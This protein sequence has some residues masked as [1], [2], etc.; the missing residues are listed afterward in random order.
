MR[1]RFGPHTLDPS[2]CTLHRDGVP[3]A[4]QPRV[5]DLIAHLVKHRGRL[6]TKEELFRDVWAGVA[7][8][9]GSLTQTVMVARKVLGDE[10]PAIETSRGRGY[11][12][13]A[14]VIEEHE[15]A[16]VPAPAERAV[17]AGA[18]VGRELALGTVARVVD[19]ARAGAMRVLLVSGEPGIGKSRVLREA[20]RLARERGFRVLAARCRDGSE[21]APAF[22]PFAEV[23][24]ALFA[25]QDP[26]KVR[27]LLDAVGPTWEALLPLVPELAGYGSGQP[28]AREDPARAR[29][30]LSNVVAQ[31]VERAALQG[32]L[33]IVLDDL[34]LADEASLG[35]LRFLAEREGAGPVLLAAAFRGREGGALSPTLAALVREETTRLVA[36]GTLDD[37][38]V[39]ELCRQTL[40][41][42]PPETVSAVLAQ[43]GGNPFFVAQILTLLRERGSADV[44]SLARE[45]Q[46]AGLGDAI[47]QHVATLSADTR[48]ML[49]AAAVLGAESRVPTLSA[50][51][52][53]PPEEIA[54]AL[55]E[56]IRRGVLDEVEGRPGA[57]RFAQALVRDALIAGLPVAVRMRLHG[58][59]GVALSSSAGADARLAE[60]AHHHHQAAPLGDAGPAI[61][62]AIR[63]AERASSAHVPEEAVRLYERAL[64]ALELSPDPARRVSVLLALGR[65]RFR[66]GDVQRAKEAFEETGKLA[67][68]LSDPRPLAEAALGY[69]ME[70]ESSAVDGRRVAFLREGLSAIEATGGAHRALVMG[71]LALAQY[72]ADDEA[73]RVG[74]AREAVAAARALSDPEALA[75]TLRCLH[76]VLLSPETTEE[77][78][79]LSTEQLVIADAVGSRDAAMRGL[80]GRIVDGLELGRL[81][82]VDA[83][84]GAYA[85]LAEE[86]RL[87]NAAWQVQRY[88]TMRALFAGA[89]DEAEAQLGDPETAAR[90]D[91][92]GSSASGLL[93]QL[94]A[95]RR[96]QGRLPELL[97]LVAEAAQRAPRRAHRRALLAEVALAC[98][99]HAT[100]RREIA[101]A[102][103]VARRKD[104]EWLAT[105]AGACRVAHALDD[106][107][108]AASLYQALSPYVARWVVVAFGAACEG[109]VALPV[110]LAALTMGDV[111][112]AER[113][114]RAAQTELSSAGA[115]PWA[116]RAGRALA[117]LR[118]RAS[119]V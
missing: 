85:R 100:A 82:D 72:F 31:L 83:D 15:P 91:S 26:P 96:E 84:I 25:E 30:R 29:F 61:D 114:L 24:R 101:A 48:E 39:A 104:L 57:F 70:E 37:G 88:R 78:L 107:E 22:W 58:R 86:T 67:R 9:E 12:F 73:G 1:Y 13:V 2:S 112:E 49:V 116:Q 103:E 118:A 53:R 113:L 71:R 51:T 93:A 111:A 75:F 5:F 109:P 43:A 92:R 94:V 108:L 8:S 10:P 38:A 90:A 98:G 106:G 35:L 20:R 19:E 17:A 68:G 66:A 79:A 11:R 102:L 14:P 36:L 44:S 62:Y 115:A 4:I 52:G 41:D 27:V 97:P 46:R 95:L 76:F 59:A 34:H 42:V 63:A 23:L 87:P 21:G 77:R 56:A 117:S 69:A 32:P 80:A 16:Q 55:D 105:L 6:V 33:A 54:S 3:V 65:E 64:D 74:L 119:R 110:G 40:G 47:R 81:R 18:L 99:D 89:L 50:M 28:L 45:M 7:V 60:I